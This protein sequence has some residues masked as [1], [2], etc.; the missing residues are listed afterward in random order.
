MKKTFRKS[1]SLIL[2][3]I[4][5]LST[6][7]V[8]AV[9]ASAASYD[10]NYSKYNVPE[11]ND[12]ARWNGSRM[13]KG[14][15]TSK[16]EVKWIQ[17]SLNYLIANRG[18][19]ASYLTV[20]GNYGPS[21][22]KAVLAYQ[23]QYGL[24]ADGSFGS[25]S[26]TKMKAVLADRNIS[27]ASIFA[28]L[29]YNF[30]PKGGTMET[31][32]IYSSNGQVTMPYAKKEGKTL[33]GWMHSR[34]TNTKLYK[35][36]V[37]Y[38]LDW[39]SGPP[40]FYA[41][42]GDFTQKNIL[43]VD[44]DASSKYISGAWYNSKNGSGSTNSIQGGGCGIVS[45]VSAVYNLGGTMDDSQVATAIEAVF[46]WAYQKRYWNNGMKDRISFFKNVD[47]KFGDKYGFSV[48]NVY[49]KTANDK[50]L[51]EHVKN[52]GTAVVRVF[53][54]YMVVVDYKVENGQGMFYV[55]DPAPGSGTNYN[56]TNRRGV[57]EA[58]GSWIS[59]KN[60]TNDGGTK[61]EKASKWENVEI[62]SFWLVSR[63]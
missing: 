56:S 25:A 54:H 1:I 14:S 18:L 57:T 61:G 44:A 43:Q 50:A 20:D 21:T 23:K 51:I 15:G 5:L 41:V 26:I 47:E 45:L 35:P 30:D 55:F 60:L 38:N 33:L 48:S 8:F 31:T 2:V 59:V 7:S 53:N 39:T 19:K 37:T 58:Q 17:A 27:N 49:S 46:D 22:Q 42:W 40:I 63:K 24:S 6:F 36:G 9:S 13:V 12:F 34:S 28:G 29:G 32:K 11:S 3:V 62:N 4:T 16:E 52:G 10:T